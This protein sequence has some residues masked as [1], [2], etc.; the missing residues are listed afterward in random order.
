M[1]NLGFVGYQLYSLPQGLL[2]IGPEV[3]EDLSKKSKEDIKDIL[4]KY[5]EESGEEDVYF[6]HKINRSMLM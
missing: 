4:D 5:L 6:D 1:A 3:S 2:V